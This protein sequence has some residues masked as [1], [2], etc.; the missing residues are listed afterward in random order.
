MKRIF[1]YLKIMEVKDIN[2]IILGLFCSFIIFKFIK[3][4]TL[5]IDNFDNTKKIYET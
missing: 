4:I 2:G 1:S 5:E 3:N